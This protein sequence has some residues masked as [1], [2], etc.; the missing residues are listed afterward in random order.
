MLMEPAPKAL[1]ALFIAII[2]MI[3]L[4]TVQYLNITLLA[5]ILML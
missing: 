3:V 1:V 4:L 5:K 2:D